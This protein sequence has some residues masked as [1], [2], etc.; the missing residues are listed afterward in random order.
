VANQNVRLTTNAVYELTP[1]AVWRGPLEAKGFGPFKGHL[2]ADDVIAGPR[3]RMRH[4]LQRHDLVAFHL[5]ALIEAFDPGVNANRKVCGLDKSPT[6]IP[7]AVFGVPLA[8]DFAITAPLT[9]HTATIGGKVPHARKARHRPRFHQDRQRE[10]IPNP[11]HG[12]EPGHLGLRPHVAYHRPLQALDL[13][14]QATQNTQITSD[15]QG[16]VGLREL[17]L[18]VAL[19][20]LPNPVRAPRVARVA[21]KL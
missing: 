2:I 9:L 16:H 10:N 6:E 8:F 19:A 20:E 21:G 12:F 17:P 4:G 7:V 1:P 11:G 3:S 13:R 15:G 14:F 5:L 18:D